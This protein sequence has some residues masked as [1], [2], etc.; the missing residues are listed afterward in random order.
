MITI[1][2]IFWLIFGGAFLCILWCIAGLICFCT[3]ILIPV[4][5]QCFKYAGFVLWPFG[6]KINYRSSTVSSFFNIIW[7]ILLGWELAIA[8]LI[9]GLIWCIT[10]IGI[11][12]GIQFIKFAQLALF[13]FGS[14]AT[15]V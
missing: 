1:G 14:K 11:P 3:I 10:I 7:I 5:Y 8:S 9:I 2:N 4:G 12:F 6:K 15:R 13:P